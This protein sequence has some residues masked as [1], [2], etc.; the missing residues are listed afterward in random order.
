MVDAGYS[1]KKLLSTETIKSVILIYNE[2]SHNW[3]VARKVIPL[4]WVSDIIKTAENWE[5]NVN[6]KRREAGSDIQM[7]KGNCF[8]DWVTPK[9]MKLWENYYCHEIGGKKCTAPPTSRVRI[10]VGTSDTAIKRQNKKQR[11]ELASTPA[12]STVANETPNVGSITLNSATSSI[13]V[14]T[15]AS[16]TSSNSLTTPTS[17]TPFETIL[18]PDPVFDEA[19]GHLCAESK[20]QS[21]TLV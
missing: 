21:D 5:D 11:I 3:S 10:N 2:N 15:I 4:S 12:V 16:T 7:P 19:Y 17:F 14:T 18:R 13:S 20:A 9:T 8:T 6:K 1:N